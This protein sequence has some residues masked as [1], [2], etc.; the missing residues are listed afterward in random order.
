[1]SA[2]QVQGAL[3]DHFGINFVGEP[4]SVLVDRRAFTRFGPFDP[5]LV[6]LCDFE[7]WA[8]VGANTG[9]AY[10][11]ESLATFRVH[12]GS[13]SETNRTRLRFH[14]DWLDP[15]VLRAAPATAPAFAG[16][17]AMAGRRQVDLARDAVDLTAKARRH[18]EQ[19]LRATTPRDRE[20]L[21]AWRRVVAS[22][23]LLARSPRLRALEVKYAAGRRLRAQRAGPGRPRRPRLRPHP[24]EAAGPR[25]AARVRVVAFYL[26]QFHPIPENDEWWGRGFTEWTQRAP[27]AGRCSPATT[28]R[29][30]PAD[31]GFYDLRVPEVRARAGRAGRGRT[32]ST[33]SATTTTGS[34]AGG[35]WSGRSTR[36]WRRASPTSR[37]AC[38]GRTS[39]GRGAG[40]A[41]TGDVLIE[42]TYSARPTTSRTSAGCAPAFRRPALHPRR[43]HARCSSSTGPTTCPTPART[44]D[45][46]RAEAE[47]AGSAS[48]Y[49]CRSRASASERGDPGA[50]SVSTPRSS[51]SPTVELG[52]SAP[53]GVARRAATGSVARPQHR[54][55]DYAIAWPR[56]CRRGRQPSFPPL[57][58]SDARV[59]QHPAAPARRRGPHRFDA[60]ALRTLARDVRRPAS[61]A[62]VGD[63]RSSSSTRGTSGRR[64][65]ISSPTRASGAATWRPPGGRSSG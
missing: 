26:P 28:S 12:A 50:R 29:T 52:R 56:P 14:K 63:E 34:R 1:M 19:A 23:P 18:A 65:T 62:T 32:A 37:S 17:R 11:P 6:A 51:S 20:P 21:D 44:T 10:V 40:T 24:A 41:A 22:Y 33:A 35:C 59:G 27:S 16:V 47:R 60:R 36:C 64:A 54:V 39:P 58:G 38:A 4:T 5:A 53:A 48:L 2:E 25:A 57:P 55:Y 45:I 7:Y 9:L 13:A 49:L 30:C 3:L 61:G 31:L 42:Q 46:W 8:R 15:L 43:R